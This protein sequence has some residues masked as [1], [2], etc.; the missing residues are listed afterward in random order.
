MA[1]WNWTIIVSTISLR[2]QSRRHIQYVTHPLASADKKDETTLNNKNIMS[3]NNLLSHLH[4]FSPFRFH[5]KPKEDGM[6]EKSTHIRYWDYHSVYEKW[7]MFR[8]K[9]PA[10]ISRRWRYGKFISNVIKAKA[11]YSKQLNSHPGSCIRRRSDKWSL[12][13]LRYTHI[14]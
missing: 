11:I 5:L 8:N 4:K 10:F 1:L 2:S 9:S 13:L 6:E 3:E 12:F 7:F 14:L